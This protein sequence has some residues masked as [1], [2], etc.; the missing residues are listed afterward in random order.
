MLRCIVIGTCAL[1]FLHY[2]LLYRN[3]QHYVTLNCSVKPSL[4]AGGTSKFISAL[5]K[6][7]PTIKFHQQG[8]PQILS[9]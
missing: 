3:T 9:S 8:K 2:V 1:Q 5:A 6:E 4:R 7:S